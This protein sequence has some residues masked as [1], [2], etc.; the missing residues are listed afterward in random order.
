M[1]RALLVLFLTFFSALAGFGAGAFAASMFLIAPGAG[2]AGA[3]EAVVY[4]TIAAVAAGIAAGFLLPR[5]SIRTLG[6]ASIA[7]IILL[8]LLVAWRLWNDRAAY[9]TSSP[10][11]TRAITET[12]R[13]ETP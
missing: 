2:L 1:T 10:L 8:I 13:E 9:E 4:G 12:P 5:L 6:R 3:T 7:A 11:P